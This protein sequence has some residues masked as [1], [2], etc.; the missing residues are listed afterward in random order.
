[1]NQRKKQKNVKESKRKQPTLQEA[2]YCIYCKE[3]CVHPISE[4]WI[5]CTQCLLWC[6]NACA[7]QDDDY[8]YEYE[9]DFCT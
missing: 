5:Q 4:N 8:E 6:H 3:K 7:G 9:C 2:D 1:M